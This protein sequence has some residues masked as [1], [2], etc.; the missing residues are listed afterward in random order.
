MH[1]RHEVVHLKHH[2]QVM[3]ELALI[4]AH[5]CAMTV[6]LLYC[7]GNLLEFI[8]ISCLLAWWV[9]FLLVFTHLQLRGIQARGEASGTPDKTTVTEAVK[10]LTSLIKQLDSLLPYLSVAIS[11]VNL[12]NAGKATNDAMHAITVA[13]PTSQ[14][15]P[16]RWARPSRSS[17]FFLAINGPVTKKTHQSHATLWC[18]VGCPNS[19]PIPPDGGLLADQVHPHH[20]RGHPYGSTPSC[21]AQ[22]RPLSTASLQI[23]PKSVAP[24]LCHTLMAHKVQ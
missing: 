13:T 5:P 21:V 16:A 1:V 18:R 8:R 11:A 15:V 17:P 7:N 19:I 3:T 9:P 22:A 2:Q 6:S 24:S 23:N 12:L 14:D 4:F 10:K 20:P